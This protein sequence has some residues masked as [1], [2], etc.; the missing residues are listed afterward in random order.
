MHANRDDVPTIMNAALHSLALSAS[1]VVGA[2]LAG[3]VARMKAAV[4][5]AGPISSTGISDH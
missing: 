5:S 3:V 1:A 4:P 2:R